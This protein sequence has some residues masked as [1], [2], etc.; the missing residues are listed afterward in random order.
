MPRWAVDD[1][2]AEH[3]AD[4]LTAGAGLC[5]PVAV[6]TLVEE[7]GQAI[8]DLLELGVGF[9]VDQGAPG[10]WPAP[11]RAGTRGRGSSTPAATP[12]G[13]SWSGPDRGGGPSP[14]SAASSMPSWSTS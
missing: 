6:R 3:V 9:D 7:G 14:R 10:R 11:E 13:P 5:D 12:P 1:S 8:T 4:T 2:V